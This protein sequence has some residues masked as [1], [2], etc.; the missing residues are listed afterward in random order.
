M[1]GVTEVL[2][3][4]IPDGVVRVSQ[5]VVLTYADTELTIFAPVIPDSGNESSLAVLF[6]KENCDI[7]ITGD[8]GSFAERMLLNNAKIPDLEILVVG[9]HGSKHSTCDEFLSAVTPEIA[10]ISVGENSFGHPAQEVLDRLYNYGCV[11]YRTDIH[12]NI[13]FRR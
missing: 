9:H 11:V 3:R 13:T 12:G 1:D 2:Q 8:R 6:R 4:M 7:L 5:D 10:V